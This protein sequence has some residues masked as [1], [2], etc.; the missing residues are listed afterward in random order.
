MNRFSVYVT[1]EKVPVS[2]V[3]RALESLSSLDIIGNSRLM[4]ASMT[5]R[6][7]ILP[8]LSEMCD[9]DLE[10][11]QRDIISTASLLAARMATDKVVTIRRSVSRAIGDLGE[12]DAHDDLEIMGD[13]Y[14]MSATRGWRESKAMNH[15][16]CDRDD[17]RDLEYL[18]EGIG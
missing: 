14:D 12:T 16:K 6:I 8:A 7:P 2:P 3:L 15:V 4:V 10:R 5:R 18:N 1:I 9:V 11:L 13:E 17:R